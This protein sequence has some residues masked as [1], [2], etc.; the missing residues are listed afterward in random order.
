MQFLYRNFPQAELCPHTQYSAE[1][2]E[3]AASQAKSWL[4]DLLFLRQP[5]P[6]DAY[7]VE[8]TDAIDLEMPQ[9]LQE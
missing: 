3:T 4:H 8:Y 7:V 6:E 2:A 5:A 1:A 9:F